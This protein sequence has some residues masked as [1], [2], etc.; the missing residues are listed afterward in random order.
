MYATIKNGRNSITNGARRTALDRWSGRAHPPEQAGCPPPSVLDA[1]LLEFLRLPLRAR[2][3]PELG[4]G[5]VGLVV[6]LR[7][8]QAVAPRDLPAVHAPDLLFDLPLGGERLG[9]EDEPVDPEE[10]EAADEVCDDGGGERPKPTEP[11]K[12]RPGED[13]RREMPPDEIKA[14]SFKIYFHI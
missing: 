9:G 7:P 2:F 12:K 4:R 11:R 6:A 3:A 14:V 1:P 5:V 10:D 13:R 8:D